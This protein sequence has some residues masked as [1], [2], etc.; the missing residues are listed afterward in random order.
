MQW[1][2]LHDFVRHS[3]GLN[4]TGFMTGKPQPAS[5]ATVAWM[6]TIDTALIILFSVI[7]MT[8]HGGDLGFMSIARVALPFLVP[9]LLLAL[10]IKPSQL[11]HNIFP[12]GIVLWL[13]TVVLG[14]ILR[15]AVFNDTSAM[16]FILVTA[17]V[18]AVFLLGRRIISALLIRK[19]QHA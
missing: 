15:A 19:K 2:A 4:Y 17:G 11:I 7:G 13:T 6:L 12:I 8:S 18:L 14:P 3:P 16:P 10:A 9:Y 5:K 1:C